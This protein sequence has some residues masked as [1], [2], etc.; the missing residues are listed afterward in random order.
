VPF[1]TNSHPRSSRSIEVRI[2]ILLQQELVL[3]S[4]TGGV[5]FARIQSEDVLEEI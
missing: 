5:S 2:N 4:L 1:S 3:Q